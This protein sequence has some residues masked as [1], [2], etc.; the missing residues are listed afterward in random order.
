ME[1][2]LPQIFSFPP[3]S[4]VS[5]NEYDK[6][7]KQLVKALGEAGS[8]VLLE[9]TPDGQELL[10]LLN[11]SE[12]TI[13][14]MAV[15]A[16]KISAQQG[17]ASQGL[18]AT[19]LPDGTL[20]EKIVLFLEAFD[21]IQIRYV[22]SSLTAL[23]D[24]V[25]KASEQSSQPF[26]VLPILRD[27]I[28]RLDPSSSTLTTTHLHFVYLCLRLKLYR[29]ALP[30]LALNIYNVPHLHGRQSP[31]LCAQGSSASYLTSATGLTNEITTRDYLQ[32]FLYGALISIALRQWEQ[33]LLFLETVLTTPTYGSA[34]L[35]Q[36]EA[37]K[38]YVLIGLLLKGTSQSLP[39]II[40]QQTLKNIKALS[41]PYDVIAETFS[42]RDPLRLQLDIEAGRQDGI[43]ARDYNLGLI[44]E[45]YKAYRQFAV[46]RL[47]NTFAALPITEVAQ[48]TSPD[49]TDLTETTQYI[50][51]LIVSGDLKAF[52]SPDTP[53]TLR[54]LPSECTTKTETQL[55]IE[56][57]THKAKLACLLELISN[58]DHL[59]ELNKEYIEHLQRLKRSRDDEEKSAKASGAA[60]NGRN[61]QPSGLMDP[62]DEDVMADG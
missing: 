7:A 16:P 12:N 35:I 22:G 26:I 39:K 25:V 54:F 15:L 47:A 10:S 3:P 55:Q 14:Y 30:I 1:S 48:R 4:P 44:S 40:H 49:P 59:L 29:E 61:G 13:A 20:Y 36:V 9:R 2:L 27:V 45:V 11:P 8:D 57:E 34:S 32:Y 21:P 5:D 62:F 18:P 58:N 19:L 24:I 31:I 37:Y 41:R 28:L 17:K 50:S 33:A 6:Q 46:L 56:I 53:P 23:L 42:A 60:G 51:D 52:I 43:W 38:K